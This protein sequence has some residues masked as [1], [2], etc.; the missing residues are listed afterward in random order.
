MRITR[1]FH[2]PAASAIADGDFFWFDSPD[3]DVPVKVPWSVIK[4]GMSSSLVTGSGISD[5]TGTVFKSSVEKVG[6]FFK[7]TIFLDLTGLQSSTTDLDIIG[8]GLSAAYLAQITAAVNGTLF[9]G[10]ITC[11]E[12]PA[13]GVTDIDLY[14]AVEDTGVFDGGIG[15]LDETALLTKGGAWSAAIAT[16]IALTALPAA[17]EFLYLTCGAAGTVGTYTAGQFVIELWGV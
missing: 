2:R 15:L 13:T 12:T 16:P 14:S 4:A 7:T 3:G 11:L 8:S 10:S 1:F 6:D 5:G 17:D 9:A